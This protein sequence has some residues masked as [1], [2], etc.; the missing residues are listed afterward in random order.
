MVDDGVTPTDAIITSFATTPA[1]LVM[2]RVAPVVVAEAAARNAGTTPAAVADAAAR[3][4][5]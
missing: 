2:V 1:G 4:P 3:K 5:I